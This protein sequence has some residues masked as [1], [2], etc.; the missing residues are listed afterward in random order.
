MIL[1]PIILNYLE[2]RKVNSLTFDILMIITFAV[3][4]RTILPHVIKID[5]FSDFI[6][7]SYWRIL[8]STIK[9][10]PS[11]LIGC[12]CAKYNLFNKFREGFKSKKIY[13]KSFDIKYLI[14]VCSD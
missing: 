8:Y 11:F 1:S 3:I 2:E 7:S 10:L 5:I 14:I 13:N 4:I 6:K 12:I 9:L